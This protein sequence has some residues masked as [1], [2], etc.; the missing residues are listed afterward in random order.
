MTDYFALLSQPRQPWLNEDLLK[1]KFLQMSA[2]VHPDR[3]HGASEKEKQNANERFSELNSAYN[4]LREPN[5]RLQ[6]LFGLETDTKPKE[7]QEIPSATMD[8][9]LE[10]GQLCREVDSFLSRRAE[11]TSPLV[12]V[13]MF[14]RA[15][16]WTDRLNG[17]QR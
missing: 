3:V 4:C 13:E 1:A 14:E 9:F 8:V 12:K 7:V 10:I 5:T 15:Q 11:V 2:E 16:E 17:V 6:H